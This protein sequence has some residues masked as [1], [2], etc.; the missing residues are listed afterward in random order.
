MKNKLAKLLLTKLIISAGTP[1]KPNH[2][3]HTRHIIN[4]AFVI[5]TDDNTERHPTTIPKE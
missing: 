4:A 1:A 3:Q 2:I 5:T